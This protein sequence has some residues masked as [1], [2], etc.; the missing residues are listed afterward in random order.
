[1]TQQI[2]E[3]PWFMVAQFTLASLVL[4]LSTPHSRLRLMAALVQFN[5]ALLYSTWYGLATP[6]SIQV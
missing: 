5:L 4:G 6:T 2:P 3:R 1:M